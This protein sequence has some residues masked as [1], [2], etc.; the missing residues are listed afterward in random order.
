MRKLQVMQNKVMRLITGLDYSTSTKTLL[1][2]SQQLSVH[3]LVAYHTLCQVH[4]LKLSKLPDYHYQRLFGT[5][6]VNKNY[7]SRY[8][9]KRVDFSLSLG[10][11]HFFYQ[12]STTYYLLPSK[13]KDIEKISQFKADCKKWVTQHIQIKP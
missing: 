3:Q 12:A 4:K 11:S 2:A 13:I 6:S 9:N 5:Q 10:R 1:T 8:M 7:S